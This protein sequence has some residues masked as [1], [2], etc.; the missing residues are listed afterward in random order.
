[1]LKI[2][3]R[4]IL[5][6]YL[7]TFSVM[8][9]MFIPIG[10]V[11]DVSEKINKMIE[12]QVAFSAIAKYYLDFT[13]YFANL[14]F[15]I[16]LFLSVIWF[17]SKLAN[18]T[19]I[20]AILSSGISFSRFLR[21]YII[22]A[23]IVSI[24]ALIMNVYLLPNASAGFNNFRYMYLNNAGV[25]GM[26]DNSNVFRQISKDEYIFVSNFNNVSQMAFNFSMEKFEGDKLKYKLLASRI[27]WNPQ[28]KNYTLYNYTKRKVG[29]FGDIIEAG[30]VKDTIF[31]FDLEDLTPVVYIAE[32]LPI[33]ELNKFIDKEK[34]RGS[35]NINVYLVVLYKKFS[36]PVSAFI[37]TIIAVAVSSMKRRGGMGTNLAIGILLAFTFVFLDKVFGVL[38]EKSSAPPL[39]AV[40]IPNIVFGILAIYLL[41]NAKR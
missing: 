32:T 29:K 8:L 14:L 23:T 27:K 31:K 4:Y 19:E 6:R 41:K 21:P 26:R 10:I 20:I 17:T 40:W 37:L 34:A 22:G 15:P 16:F 35:S 36:I 3:D 11:I 7:V 25:E 2:I 33:N 9:L 12:H 38:A 5:K 13:I 24:A 30:E 18:N 1:M 39:I 28:K